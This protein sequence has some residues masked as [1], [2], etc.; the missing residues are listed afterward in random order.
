MLIITGIYHRVRNELVCMQNYY[1][2]RFLFTEIFYYQLFFN[3]FSFF[4]VLR[5]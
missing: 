5:E 2:I 4:R 3:S 1:T